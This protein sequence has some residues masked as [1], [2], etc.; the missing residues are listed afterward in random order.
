MAW[1]LD[2]IVAG[3]LLLEHC[4]WSVVAVTRSCC[5]PFPSF[6]FLMACFVLQC[7]VLIIVI[8]IIKVIVVVAVLGKMVL[9]WKMLGLS[10]WLLLSL[11]FCDASALTCSQDLPGVAICEEFR[12]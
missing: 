2:V 7:L 5:V 1:A 8:V 10:I 11:S 4:C 9:A 3:A 12:I 6:C